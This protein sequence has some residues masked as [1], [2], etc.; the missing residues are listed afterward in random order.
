MP[1]RFQ[2]VSQQGRGAIHIGNQNARSAIIIIIGD[3]HAAE[4]A[5]VAIE[6]VL[7]MPDMAVNF[8]PIVYAVLI[9]ALV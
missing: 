8:A 4:E 1:A 3:R 2:N 5:G 6:H 9:P 7:P